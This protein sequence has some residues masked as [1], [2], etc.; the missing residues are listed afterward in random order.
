MSGEQE[1][2]STT[3]KRYFDHNGCWRIRNSDY[4]SEW[5]STLQAVYGGLYTHTGGRDQC[6]TN[7]ALLTF[8]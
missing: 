4:D 7:C 5:E 8:N 1:V 3:V 6:E 2:D